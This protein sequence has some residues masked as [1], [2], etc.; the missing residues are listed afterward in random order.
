MVDAEESRPVGANDTIE[1]TTL[2]PGRFVFELEDLASNCAVQGSNPRTLRVRGGELTSTTFEVLCGAR[3]GDLEVTA[4]TSGEDPDPDGYA[5]TVGDADPRS[6]DPNG[7]VTFADLAP[8]A[9]RV[10]LGDV[11]SNCTVEGENP[12]EAEVPAGGTGST[13]FEVVCEARTGDLEVRTSTTGVF[14]DPDGYE[15]V[16]D[17]DRSRSLAL[18]DSTTFRD[19]AAGPHQVRL[20]DVFALCSVKGA[21]P[22]QVEV[23]D[24]GTA[25][26]TFE[27]RCDDDDD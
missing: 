1:A 26:T 19:V 2:P 20:V 9:H 21:N 24:G 11:A 13:A 22:R 18:D 3:A 17:G 4:S 6:V 12:R 23:P 7:T 10:E 15:V 25:S 16:L 27:V 8:G 14:R 5:V